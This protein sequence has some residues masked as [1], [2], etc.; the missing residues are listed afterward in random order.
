MSNPAE[1]RDQVLQALERFEHLVAERD[2]ALLSEF[3]EEA[4]VRL[5]GSEAREVATGPAEVGVAAPRC[6]SRRGRRVALRPRRSGP[7]WRGYRAAR[8]LPNDR[9][10]G[11]SRRHLALAPLSWIRAGPGPINDSP[12]CDL[13]R[14]QR[15]DDSYCW[16]A[17]T[18]AVGTSAKQTKCPL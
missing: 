7:E 16:L 14:L 6:L 5:V 17:E 12:V 11:T 2:P 8:A 13:G 3:V 9:C 4:D 10:A 1:M 15:P 18:I